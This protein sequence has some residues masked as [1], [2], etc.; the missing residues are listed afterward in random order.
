MIYLIIALAAWLV[1]SIVS[2]AVYAYDK[3]IA[4]SGKRRIRERTLLLLAFFMGAPGALIAMKK[5]RHKTLHKQFTI[6][7]PLFFALQAALVAYLAVL[8]F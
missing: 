3:K 6:P 4:G 5:L 7:V 1:M 8:A 2:F